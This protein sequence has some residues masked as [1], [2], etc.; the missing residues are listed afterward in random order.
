MRALRTI[1]AVTVC[2]AVVLAGLALSGCA[3]GKPQVIVFVGKSARDTS[4]QDTKAMIDKAKKEFGDKVIFIEYDY[5]SPSSDAAKKKYTVSMNPTIIITNSQGAIKYSY[6]GK[7]MEDKLIGDIQSLLP[8]T[9]TTPATG[10]TI[11]QIQTTPGAP[12]SVPS[13]PPPMPGTAP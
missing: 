4:Y 10:G 7:P 6:L 13:L 8:Q 2:A 11:P 5:D 12:G 1:I 3:P 9:G